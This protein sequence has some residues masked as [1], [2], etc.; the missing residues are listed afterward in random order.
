MLL[1][2]KVMI[3]VGLIGEALKLKGERWAVVDC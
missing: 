3:W 2:V 1:D